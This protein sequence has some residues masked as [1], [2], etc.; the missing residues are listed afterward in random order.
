MRDRPL[1]LHGE[2]AGDTIWL[3]D[4]RGVAVGLVVLGVAVWLEAASVAVVAGLFV[5]L[6]IVAR[7]WSRLALGGLRCTVVFDEDR[8]FPDDEL[9]LLLTLENRW[10]VPIPW[11]EAELFIPH[12][13]Y[14]LTGT[15]KPWSGAGGRV[16]HV[17]TTLLPFR[18]QTWHYRLRCRARGEYVISNVWVVVS[19]A[20]RLFPR[21]LGLPV[22]ARLIVYP[23]IVALEQLGLRSRLPQGDVVLR[24]ILIEDPLRP[25]GVRDYRSGDPPKSIHWKASAR[26]PHLQTKVLERTTRLQLA[27]YLDAHCFDHPWVA[28]RETYFERA[29]TAAASLANAVSER[30]GRVALG[31]SGDRQLY[32]PAALGPDHLR[33]ILEALAVVTPRRGRPLQ[34]VLA[35]SLWRQPAGATI[36]VLVPALLEELAEELSVTRG[37]GH[38]VAILYAGME[39]ILPPPGVDLYELGRDEDLARVLS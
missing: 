36:V 13:L 2:S 23:R 32:L 29:V 10:L 20:L 11:L 37:R 21:R 24:S 35:A 34:S 6:A 17:L 15:L 14:P 3:V 27:L 26:R 16:V 7:G 9:D 39:Q 4:L 38:P 22:E 8:A 25:I 12:R 31:I 1:V 18:R 33:E 30:G 28:Y 5:A 19:D